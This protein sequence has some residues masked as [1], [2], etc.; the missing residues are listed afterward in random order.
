M[1]VLV[2]GRT[3]YEGKAVKTSVRNAWRNISAP[4]PAAGE[5]TLEVRA[6][7]VDGD[8]QPIA[9]AAPSPW[10]VLGS[11]RICTPGA[12][13][14]VLIWVSQDSLRADH[15]GAYGYGRSTTPS[16]DSLARDF[17]VFDQAFAAASWTLPS[18]TS[19]FTARYPA[20]HGSVLETKLRD[21]TLPTVFE[22]LAKQ[23]FTVLGATGNRFISHEFLLAEGFK[24]LAVLD[25]GTAEEVGRQAIALLSEWEGEDIAL[26]VHFM[27]PH[28]PYTPPAPFD[29]AFDKGYRGDVNGENFDTFRV[30]ALQ[31]SDVDHVQA[32]Y[33][34]EVAYTDHEVGV[35][36]GE[37]KRRGLLE[38]A[39]LA[40]SAD[41]GEEFLDHGGWQHSRTLYGEMLRVP[42]AVHEP[43]TP[44]R[45]VSNPVSL[46]DLAPTLLAAFGIP[47]PQAFQGRTLGPLMAGGTLPEL[48]LFAETERNLD[49]KRRLAVRWKGQKCI[50]LLPPGDDRPDILGEESFDLARDPGETTPITT[51]P[52]LRREAIA[53]LARARETPAVPGH[54][55]LSDE[56]QQRLRALGYLN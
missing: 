56:L 11:P 4:L 25:D 46:V 15:V 39:V 5:S 43:G 30:Q 24:D 21:R 19:Q 29:R 6:D 52:D 37:L 2:G 22:V 23:G 40:Y 9:D 27:D 49:K 7:Y 28:A 33:D 34:G 13:G 12:R 36:M 32:L 31:K 17:V 10:I 50:F 55:V 38:G 8:G 48:P 47:S 54:A 1:R 41:H 51:P 18:I 16:F 53:Y 45:H 20:F 35:L 3:V 26:F 42:L 14:R 44:G